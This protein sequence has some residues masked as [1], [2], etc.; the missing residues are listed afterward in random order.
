[1]LDNRGIT[2]QRIVG[3][4]M[5][6]LR[7]IR[8]NRLKIE[9]VDL[10]S[11]DLIGQGYTESEI[12]AAFNWLFTRLES[13]EPAEVMFRTASTKRSFRVLHPAETTI[14]KAEAYGQLLEMYALGL[15]SLDEMERIIERAMSFDHTLSADDVRMIVH[16]YLFEEG[17]ISARTH[18]VQFTAPN[19][20]VH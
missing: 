15:L 18:S 16:A 9:E 14:L 2:P 10:I 20:T 6:L 19:N 1:M 8:E 5:H 12:T 4:V 13:E 11:E 3:L 7:E 17:G